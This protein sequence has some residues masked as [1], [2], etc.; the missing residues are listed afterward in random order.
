MKYMLIILISLVFLTLIINLPLIISDPV[1]IVIDYGSTT[2]VT[3]TTVSSTP[4]TQQSTSPPSG[5]HGGSTPTT[6]PIEKPVLTYSMPASLDINQDETKEFTVKVTNP[7]IFVLH[8]ITIIITGIPKN[9]YSLKPTLANTLESNKS[10]DFTVSINSQNI[11]L[12]SHTLT[13]NISSKETY[14]EITMN[15]NVKEKSAIT[16]TTFPT[17]TIPPE[18][19]EKI[20]SGI[21]FIKALLIVA[22]IIVITM[23]VTYYFSSMKKPKEL[24]QIPE[25]G[26]GTIN[27]G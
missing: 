4:T 14:E 23:V 16:T 25:E 20:K 7:S 27:G 13:F 8:D 18:E 1:E 11:T 17:A 19:E 9:S 10:T 24:P 6:I 22:G 5:D 26:E 15:L 2:T 12:G 3:S 21:S